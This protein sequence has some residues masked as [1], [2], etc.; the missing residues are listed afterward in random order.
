MKDFNTLYKLDVRRQYRRT[1]TAVGAVLLI[2]VVLMESL[3]TGYLILSELAY[4]LF[5]PT[6]AEIIDSVVYGIMYL[7]IFMV[8]AIFFSIIAG[9]N[10]TQPMRLEVKLTKDTFALIAA[11]LACAFAMS[12][13]NALVMNLFSVPES[14][15]LFIETTPYTEDYSIILQFVTMAL[16]PAFCE[17]FLFRGV[18]LSNLMPYGKA[19]AVVISSVLFG[20]MH[21]NFY[22]FLYTVAGGI[23]IGTVY[24]LTDSIWCSVFIHMINN[25]VAVFQESVISRLESDGANIVITVLEGIIFSAGLLCAIYLLHKYRK[26]ERES[27]NAEDEEKYASVF[28]KPLDSELPDDTIASIPASEALKQ[29]FNPLITVFIL[30]SL[31]R[32]FAVLAVM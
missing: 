17:E 4:N 19:T 7:A 24:V 5:V 27:K 28:G 3:P 20:C 14:V 21:G 30:Y 26:P 32:A 1:L 10:K 25:S 15:P 8:P 12:Y 29:F 6:A 16:V 31:F 22:Q 11:A 13:V 18:I 2:W 9:K 23:V